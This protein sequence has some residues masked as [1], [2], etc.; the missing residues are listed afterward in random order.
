M[1]LVLLLLAAG[2]KNVPRLAARNVSKELSLAKTYVD[3]RV[4]PVELF[5]G[6]VNTAAWNQEPLSLHIIGPP[7]SL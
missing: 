3:A 2:D 7:E 4:C 6:S 5:V 1:V